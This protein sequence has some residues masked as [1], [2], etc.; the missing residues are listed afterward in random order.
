MSRRSQG[1]NIHCPVNGRMF[2][3]AAASTV[4]SLADVNER[5]DATDA[6]V[7]SCVRAD[8]NALMFMDE[9]LGKEHGELNGRGGERPLEQG[10]KRAT[11]CCGFA[12]IIKSAP[13]KLVLAFLR[14][15]RF[16]YEAMTKIHLITLFGC[17]EERGAVGG[18]ERSEL[19]RNIKHCVGQTRRGGADESGAENDSLRI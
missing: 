17:R 13:R 14:R 19:Q 9:A 7:R 15:I 11:R 16:K 10:T 1:E 2:P 12:Q 4:C 5:I 6:T 3:F 18:A 8:N